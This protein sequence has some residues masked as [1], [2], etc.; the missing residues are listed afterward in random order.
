MVWIDAIDI[1]IIIIYCDDDDD[2]YDE[3]VGR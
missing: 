3:E 1:S 2:N